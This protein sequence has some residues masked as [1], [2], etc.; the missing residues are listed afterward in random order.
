MRPCHKI[1]AIEYKLAAQKSNSDV[2][3]IPGP[4]LGTQQKSSVSLTVH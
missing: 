1:Y 3:S 2:M 4:V